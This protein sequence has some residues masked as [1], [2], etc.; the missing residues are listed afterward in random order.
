MS[1]LSWPSSCTSRQRYERGCR[2]K[3]RPLNLPGW[4]N[5]ARSSFSDSTRRAGCSNVRA[6][7]IRAVLF[8]CVVGLSSAPAVVQAADTSAK[9]SA[10]ADVSGTW[11]AVVE[12]AQ[13][14]GTPV[15][16]FKQD[17]AKLTGQYKGQLGEA[18]L[19]GTVKGNEVSFTFTVNPGE[20]IKVE[21]TG[22]V[23]G[24]AMKGTTKFGTYGDG[25]FTAKKRK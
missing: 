1:A 5:V 8:L 24:T 14:T 4:K 13:G 25:S 20:E 2:P 6:M 23:D 15:F 17:G 22:T 19:T 21:Y 11:D 3:S 16:T 9:V 10:A 7:T 18:P 12:T